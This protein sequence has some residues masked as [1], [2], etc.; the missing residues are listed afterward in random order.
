MPTAKHQSKPNLT[1]TFEIINLL[2][3]KIE[4]PQSAQQ[5]YASFVLP[6][7]RKNLCQRGHLECGSSLR[8]YTAFA[9]SFGF[10]EV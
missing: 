5:V 7:L 8:Q 4:R 3:V 1:E 10:W 6:S 9:V 2:S